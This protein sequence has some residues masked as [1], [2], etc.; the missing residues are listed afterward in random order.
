MPTVQRPHLPVTAVYALLAVAGLATVALTA[1][2][3]QPGLATIAQFEGYPRLVSDAEARYVSSYDRTGGNND[4]FEGT[5]S[6]LYVDERGEHVL[7]DAAGPGAVYTMWFTSRENGWAKL[8]FGRLRFYFDDEREPRLDIDADELFSGQRPPFVAPFVFDRFTSSGGYVSYLPLPFAR[9]LK[10]TSERRVG[11][12]NVY[13]HAY[14]TT[15]PVES[16]TGREDASAVARMWSQ[17]GRDPKPAGDTA[18]FSG[19]IELPAPAMPD[20]DMAPVVTPVFEWRGTGTI[21]ALKFNPLAPLTPYQLNHLRLR[22]WFDGETTP[23]VSAPLG[24]FFGSG[25]GEASV[26]AVPLGMSPSGAYYCYLPMP[27]WERVKVEI[28]NDN[29]G[30]APPIWWEVQLAKDTGAQYPRDRSG[31][32][33]AHYRREWPTTPGQDYQLLDTSGRGVL[34][35]QVMTVE[36][37]RPEVKRWWEGDLRVYLDGRRHPAFHGTGHE[38]EYLGGWSNEW[39]MNPYSLPMHGQ[40]ATADLTQ[41]DFQWN[42]STTVYRFFPGGVPYQSHLAMSTEHGVANGAP[43][44][45]SSVVYYYE[46][47]AAM[48]IVDTLDVGN[49]GDEAAHGYVAAP[50]V[51]ATRLVSQFEGVHNTVDVTDDGRAVAKTSR[52][53]LRA[54]GASQGLRLRR[55]YDQSAAQA[56]EVWVNGAQVGVWRSAATN[57]V[58]RWAETDFL[59]PAAAGAGNARLDIELRVLTGP[60]SEYRYELW[61][62]P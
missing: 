51:P 34:V 21:T 59:L 25:L 50:A 14:A 60:W 7:F 11:F 24:S 13:S 62:I 3:P 43:A 15:R 36:P 16:W 58:K 45:Y 54:P 30:P 53:S 33:K 52:F 5:Y 1:Q 27:F 57:T 9:R 56:A 44:M 17:T 18:T 47:P 8:G 55:L 22:I 4:G 37:I 19:T 48:R 46:H 38:D 26:R 6:A 2:A 39:L 61:A 29:P 10:I 20:G 23:S 28:V 12:Y 35:G 31:Y 40:P 41:V 42:A 49:A 32:F